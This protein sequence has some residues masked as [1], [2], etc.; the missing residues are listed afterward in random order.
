MKDESLRTTPAAVVVALVALVARPSAA[1][2]QDAELE[3]AAVSEIISAHLSHGIGVSPFDAAIAWDSVAGAFMIQARNG[4]SLQALGTIEPDPDTLRAKLAQLTRAGLLDVRGDSAFATLPI[5][6]GRERD[7][8]RRVTDGA[9]RR[10]LRAMRPELESLLMEL[11]KRGWEEWSYHFLWSQLFDSQFAWVELTSRRLVPPL[12]PPVAWIVYPRHEFM[13]GTNYYPDDEIG[14]WFLP[15]TWTPAGANT[16]AT[17]GDAWRD[18]FSVT[19]ADDAD[20]GALR[21]LED[22]GLRAVPGTHPVPVVR[23]DDPLYTL[24]AATA[25]H[26]VDAMAANLPDELA[27]FA[28]GERRLAFAMAYHDVSWEILALLSGEGRLTRPAALEP[29]ADPE[30]PMAGVAAIVA[31][32]PPF[33]E[34]LRAALTAIDGG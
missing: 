14:D 31:A 9:A 8:Y 34:L 5:L 17:L 3:R 32:Y 25:K 6:L 10:V 29:R 19:L 2:A 24:L 12:A 13:S 33:V 23:G 21:R 1:P 30:T 20:P 16:I 18:I 27:A 15:V 4:A 11:E 22:A 28:N 7:A 26:H